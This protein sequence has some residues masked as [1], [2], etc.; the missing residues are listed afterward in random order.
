M[1][2]DREGAAVFATFVAVL[3][4]GGRLTTE[5]LAMEFWGGGLG[6]CELV[7]GGLTSKLLTGEGGA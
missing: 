6:A 1:G 7:A 2:C 3:L 4:A 5:L